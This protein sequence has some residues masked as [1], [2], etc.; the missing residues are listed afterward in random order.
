MPQEQSFSY[1]YRAQL[2]VA[3]KVNKTHPYEHVSGSIQ[4]VELQLKESKLVLQLIL[5]MLS[6]KLHG[7]HTRGHLNNLCICS[8]S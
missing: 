1:P 8:S 3:A 4:F 6:E 5:A 7:L 2:R